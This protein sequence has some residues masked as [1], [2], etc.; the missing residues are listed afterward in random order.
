[1]T[2]TPRVLVFTD[3]DSYVKWGAALANQIP[4]D[5]S[6]RLVYARSNAEPSPRQLAEA[7]EGSRFEGDTPTRVAFADLRDI[8]EN[9]RPD[10]V[11]AAARGPAVHALVGL[12]ANVPSRPV[13]VSGLAGISVP[14]IPY[15]LGF[16]RAVD[17]FVLHSHREL[18]EFAVA[19]A[20]LGIRHTYELATLPFLSSAPRP[21]ETDSMRQATESEPARDRI[22]FAA[23]ALVPGSRRE[24]TWLLLQLI[25]T[26]RA[27]PH[28]EVVI[29]VRARGGEPQT[30]AEH[31]SYEDLLT[32]IVA[33]GERVPENLVVESG[34]MGRHLR[35]AV[36]LVTVSS[37]S[38]L[39]AT[40]EGIPCLALTDFGV[41]AEQINLVLTESGLLGTTRDLVA[42]AFRHPDPEWLEDNYFHDPADNSWLARVEALLELRRRDGLPPYPELPRTLVARARA[43]AYRHFAFA[44]A[45]GSRL[46]RI[47]SRVLA[48]GLW[49]NRRRREIVRAVRRF[50][51]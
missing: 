26:A 42:A 30:H 41:G 10:V 47:E 5:W 9:W 7:L 38:L 25:E 16:R 39:E 36:G 34:A 15:G 31:F 46:E 6:V 3:S 14:V 11:V 13:L 48:V 32:R 27:H 1:M 44:S 29:K 35:R 20:Q 23:Q 37:T 24:R 51:A 18:R 22:I 17:V 12:I 8:L 33:S 40:A 4:K 28:L 49:G 45:E 43:R 19:S 2:D 21:V 50:G